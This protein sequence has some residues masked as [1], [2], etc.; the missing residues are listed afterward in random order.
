MQTMLIVG[1][2][3][4]GTYVG[5]LWLEKGHHVYAVTTSAERASILREQGFHPIVA[6]VLDP[7]SLKSLPASDILLYSVGPGGQRDVS[8]WKLYRD[9]LAHVLDTVASGCSRIA[10]I[11]ST[12]V[13][14]DSASQWI[15]E[16]NPKKPKRESSQA[17]AAAE[18]LLLE[19]RW[20]DRAFVFRL[21]GLYG[22]DRIPLITYLLQG[23]HLPTRPDALLNLIH[24][25][26]A[27]TA[28]DLV[29]HR[30]TPPCVV[31]VVDGHPVT[32]RDFYHELSKLLG[33]APPQFA[34]RSDVPEREISLDLSRHY[35]DITRRYGTSSK[36]VSNELLVNH[37][38]MVFRY[39]DYRNGLADVVQR[40]LNR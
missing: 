38:G 40:G 6:D 9:G 18:D 22:P 30:G 37:F 17:L 26:D 24:L 12:G 7:Q 21:G 33:V 20:R 10:L 5:R 29:L 13:Y 15:D 28:I 23:Q 3:Y 35:G 1:C 2:G 16:H 4:L 25:D 31:N 32:R 27:A 14:G 39:P 36:R 34:P 19:S 8:R 11:S